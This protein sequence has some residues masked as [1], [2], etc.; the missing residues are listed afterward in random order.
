MQSGANCP[1]VKMKQM[2]NSVGWKD[3]QETFYG[4]QREIESE[5]STI[6]RRERPRTATNF[7]TINSFTLL[8]AERTQ[9]VRASGSLGTKKCRSRPASLEYKQIDTKATASHPTS[10][11]RQIL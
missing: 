11:L 3:I 9:K 10:D 1:I 4:V 5:R 2:R 8:N 6:R 7:K